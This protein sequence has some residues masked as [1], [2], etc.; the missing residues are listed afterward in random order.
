[1][2][3]EHQLKGLK[4]LLDKERAKFEKELAALHL[5]YKTIIINLKD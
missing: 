4:D 2:D 5:Y 1:M 3:L